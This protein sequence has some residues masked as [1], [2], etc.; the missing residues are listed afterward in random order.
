MRRSAKTCFLSQCMADL[1]AAGAPRESLVLMNFEDD[2]LAGVD[3]SDLS[4]L[5]ESYYQLHPEFRDHT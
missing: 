2:R 5:L 3:A 1:L 4:F